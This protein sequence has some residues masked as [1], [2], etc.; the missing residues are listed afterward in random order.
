MY[1]HGGFYSILMSCAL[2]TLD[3]VL[4]ILFC[5]CCICR[6]HL[7]AHTAKDRQDW[8]SALSGAIARSGSAGASSSKGGVPVASSHK[9]YRNLEHTPDAGS[10]AE[11]TKAPSTVTEPVGAAEAAAED[12]SEV[13]CMSR[14]WAMQVWQLSVCASW[15]SKLRVLL[16]LEIEWGS[17]CWQTCHI[18]ARTTVM[19]YTTCFC[20]HRIDSNL[21]TC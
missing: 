9:Q 1:V 20:N 6:T 5:I 13:S 2:L 12:G 16:C 4:A 10:R 8:M 11:L 14:P 17:C 19:H 18:L 7:A 3:L 21:G 15:S